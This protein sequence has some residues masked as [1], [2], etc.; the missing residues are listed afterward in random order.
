MSRSRATYPGWWRA[1]AVGL[2]VALLLGLAG[3]LPNGTVPTA[4]ADTPRGST[5][6]LPPVAPAVRTSAPAAAPAAAPLPLIG[7]VDP[8]TGQVH[9]A[10]LGQGTGPI[11]PFGATQPGASRNPQNAASTNPWRELPEGAFL[12]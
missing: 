11:N 8:A 9:G 5:P 7:S 1:S 4:F 6:L 3:L 10:A 2:G 12:P